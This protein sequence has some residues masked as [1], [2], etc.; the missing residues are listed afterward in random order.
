M[1]VF[2][3]GPIANKLM[4]QMGKT[5]RSNEDKFKSSNRRRVVI[6]KGMQT[7]I[8]SGEMKKAASRRTR[9]S[10]ADLFP[11]IELRNGTRMKMNERTKTMGTKM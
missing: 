2:G 7:T 6:M 11:G 10:V 3:R 8:A 9:F 1:N 4:G 5:N